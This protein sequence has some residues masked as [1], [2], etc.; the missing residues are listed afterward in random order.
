[1]ENITLRPK[2]N[3]D[4]TVPVAAE[5]SR[6]KMALPVRSS[7]STSK[8][9]TMAAMGALKMAAMAAVDPHASNRVVCFGL[10]WKK[11]AK[12]EPMAEPVSTIGAS[13]PTDPPKPTVMALDTM[14]E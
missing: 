7:M 2:K 5:I 10:R 13:R 4:I 9:K 11:R 12:F 8:V 6:G 14:E 3:M 1:M